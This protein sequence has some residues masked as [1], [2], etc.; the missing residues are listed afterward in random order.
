MPSQQQHTYAKYQHDQS[1]PQVDIEAKGMDLIYGT[2]AGRQAI[3]AD[4][5]TQYREHHADRQPDIES[6][7]LLLRL[8][9]NVARWLQHLANHQKTQFTTTNNTSA[10]AANND[11]L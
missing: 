10:T 3:G 11:G 9:V 2:A 1:P 6:H 5:S 7:V 4:K 8:W